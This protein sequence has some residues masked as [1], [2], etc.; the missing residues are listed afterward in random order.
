MIGAFHIRTAD[1]P[2]SAR[3]AAEPAAAPP[4]EPADA[5]EEDAPAQEVGKW[6]TEQITTLV[7]S[8]QDPKARP[9]CTARGRRFRRPRTSMQPSNLFSCFAYSKPLRAPHYLTLLF[10]TLFL[11]FF[12]VVPFAPWVCCFGSDAPSIA[13]GCV[14]VETLFRREAQRRQGGRPHA[15]IDGPTNRVKAM[16]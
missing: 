6:T 3:A 4:P 1:V 10:L 11:W 2:A 9:S 13:G 16:R 8:K 7:Q 14:C 15:L 12:A 5:D